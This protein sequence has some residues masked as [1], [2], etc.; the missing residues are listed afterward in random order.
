M[1]SL[2]K[3]T[4]ANAL[5][6]SIAILGVSDCRAD[7]L[8]NTNLEQQFQSNLAKYAQKSTMQNTLE[9]ILGLT[10][11]QDHKSVGLGFM[12]QLIIRDSQALNITF[13][14]LLREQ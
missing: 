3:A 6:A 4:F 11:N 2:V 9:S 10:F 14:E 7:V 5:L 8:I 1:P 13:L 12:D